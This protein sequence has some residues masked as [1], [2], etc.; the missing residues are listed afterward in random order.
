[1]CGKK[2]FNG[3]KII[4]KFFHLKI[5]FSTLEIIGPQDLMFISQFHCQSSF[6][7]NFIVQKIS[8]HGKISLSEV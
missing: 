4:E 5:Y 1:M 2:F 6:S 3:K 8:S 7:K